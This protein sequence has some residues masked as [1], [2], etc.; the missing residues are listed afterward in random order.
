MLYEYALM[1]QGGIRCAIEDRT[2]GYRRK[3]KANEIL[4]QDEQEN[5][6]DTS[7]LNMLQLV[8]RPLYIE[9]QGLLIKSNEIHLGTK[10]DRH[11]DWRTVEALHNRCSPDNLAQLRRITL[12]TA[13][14]S[15]VSISDA[16]MKLI[17]W[18]NAFEESF[19]S[20]LNSRVTVMVHDNTLYTHEQPHFISWVVA[21]QEHICGKTTIKLPDS[22]GTGASY[23]RIQAEVSN[24]QHQ[25]LPERMRFT[26]TLSFPENAVREEVQTWLEGQSDAEEKMKGI[27]IQAQKSF[28][29]G[30]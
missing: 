23:L 4:L 13:E 26:V 15:F 2:Y 17:G 9:T 10:H 11:R 5:G 24:L 20:S 6:V 14:V 7:P 22:V 27:M 29:D 25:M 1:H 3:L 18:L 12:C 8:C 30:I 28:N 21:L 19:N 16:L